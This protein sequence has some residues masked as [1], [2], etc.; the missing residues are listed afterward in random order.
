MHICVLV[1][2]EIVFSFALKYCFYNTNVNF[3]L[4]LRLVSKLLTTFKNI[5]LPCFSTYPCVPQN[6]IFI[7]INRDFIKNS[8]QAPICTI[9]VLYQRILGKK[10]FNNISLGSLLI[11]KFLSRFI[12]TPERFY[13]LKYLQFPP[14]LRLLRYNCHVTLCKLKMYNIMI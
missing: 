2:D 12:L 7:I 14:N 11:N 5:L 4:S 8:H 13:P 9:L 3:Q 1:E 10:K 6:S